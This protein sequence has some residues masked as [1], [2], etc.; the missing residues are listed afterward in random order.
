MVAHRLSWVLHNGPIPEGLGVLH[1]CDTPL[2]VNPAHLFLGTN[3]DNTHDAQA[4][5]RLASGDRHIWRRQPERHP[6]RVRPELKR[7]TEEDVCAMRGLKQQGMT[8]AQIATR[9]GANPRT[10]QAAVSGR[11]WRW[12]P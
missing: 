8:Y 6:M 1:R 5:G 4:K 10:V 7:L 2:C 12:V 9:F 3:A 11:S